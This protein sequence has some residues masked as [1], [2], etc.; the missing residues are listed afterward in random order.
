MPKHYNIVTTTANNVNIANYPKFN[1]LFPFAD[2]SKEQEKSEKDKHKRIKDEKYNT[3]IRNTK[4]EDD[5]YKM[6]GNKGDETKRS[7]TS[8]NNL[9]RCKSSEQISH[10]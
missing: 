7:N 4:N 8:K 10:N 1:K 3:M 5:F 2:K 9:K 6:K